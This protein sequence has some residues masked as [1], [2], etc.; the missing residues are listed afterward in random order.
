MS[1][2]I[3]YETKFKKEKHWNAEH[4]RGRYLFH[5][6]TIFIVIN[7]II[8]FLFCQLKGSFLSE[9]LFPPATA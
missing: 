7:L 4:G 1:T 3:K 2:R 9:Q 5:N 8:A 6:G